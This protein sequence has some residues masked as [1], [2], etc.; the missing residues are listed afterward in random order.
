VT[1]LVLNLTCFLAI[2]KA[3]DVGVQLSNVNSP[4]RRKAANATQIAA[5]RL[6]FNS[7][8]V[9][10]SFP[11]NATEDRGCERESESLLSFSITVLS[12]PDDKVN[13]WIVEDRGEETFFV[14][15]GPE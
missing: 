11:D 1:E 2:K 7:V 6:N 10:S 5:L 12:T 8:V 14:V 9:V 4:D 15:S 13:S 3:D